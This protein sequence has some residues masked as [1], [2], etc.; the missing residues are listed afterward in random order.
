[1]IPSGWD[2]F[3]LFF[4]GGQEREREREREREAFVHWFGGNL[5][6]FFFYLFWIYF[7]A[8]FFLILFSWKYFK[9]SCLFI[10]SLHVC[11]KKKMKF[12][13]ILN[14][15]FIIF[16]FL[17]MSKVIFFKKIYIILI[18][19]QIKNIIKNNYYYNIKHN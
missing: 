11:F 12:F 10:P 19:F 1:M 4:F 17:I 16:H 5:F 18:Y 3:L 13:F 6:S 15:F 14:W 8:N 2:F 7:T 9:D